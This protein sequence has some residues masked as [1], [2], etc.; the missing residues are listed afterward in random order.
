MGLII[1]YDKGMSIL[2]LTNIRT[3]L[4]LFFLPLFILSFIILTI[5]SY[6]LSQRSISTALQ[7]T[8]LAIGTDYANRVQGDIRTKMSYLEDLSATQRVRSGD[9]NQVVVAMS[10]AYQRL[11]LFD[12]IIYIAPDGKGVRWNQSTSQYADREYFRKVMETKKPY[13]SEPLISNS[14]GKI[15]F[16]LAVPVLN[17]EHVSGVIAA[18]YSLDR[19]TEMMKDLTFLQ[20]G[21]GSIVDSSGLLLAHPKMP[22]L[23]GKL[24]YTEKQ[25]NP[26]LKVPQS[27]LDDREIA[28][29]HQALDSKKC[30][31]GNYTAVDGIEQLAVYTPIALPGGQSWIMVVAAPLTEATQ[32]TRTLARTMLLLALLFIIIAAAL[33][34]LISNRFAGSLALI[35]DECRL[36]TQ[37]D[38]RERQVK[39]TSHDEIGQLAQGFQTMR[40][41]LHNLIA[42]IQSHSEQVAASSEQL[43]AGSEQTAQAAKQVAGTIANISDGSADQLQAVDKTTGII[44]QM[45]AGI[46][47][48]A[49][50][51]GNVASTAQ[52][53][54]LA[55]QEGSNKAQKATRQMGQIEK[56]VDDSARL[57]DKLGERS[58]E[59]AAIIE[60]ISTLA[61]Q[62]NLLALNAAI[63]SARA[64]E[65]GRGFAVVADEVR[66][67]A[68][69]SQDAAQ[70]IADII[71]QIRTDTIEA[72]EAMGKGASEV[73]TGT[74]VVGDA[75]K[76][77][78]EIAGLIGQVSD[79]VN[80]ISAAIEQI[81]ARSQDIVAAIQTINQISK[82]SS[83][84]TS[85]ASASTND[86]LTSM[87]EIMSASQVL[88]KMSEDLRLAVS[89]F[90]I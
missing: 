46:Q 16:M 54:V 63:E 87:Q 37:G 38:L 22:E 74:E 80:D 67:L 19:L 65:Q 83:T 89:H 68:E 24:N 15:S 71:G 10:E 35:L 77:F 36:L 13:V 5:A 1:Y 78:D 81:A 39:I 9:K 20:T 8:A 2:K 34:V 32:E 48:I 64:G 57:V 28:L 6:Y 76:T 73:K 40:T 86:Q 41:N 79:Q 33:I 42:E 43:T 50:N 69:Q 4:L 31:M 14:T 61:S 66:K 7:S 62:T 25:I 44:E 55:A 70:Q 90:K 52:Q 58:Q 23:E 56:S 26:D 30:V 60:T 45:S 17:G 53:T 27:E 21:Y 3:K 18:T 72:V 84:Q 59:I 85:T 29:F 88:S 47:V 11:G 82:D 75:G 12:A 49:A 51:A